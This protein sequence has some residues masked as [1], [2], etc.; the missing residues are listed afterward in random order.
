MSYTPCDHHIQAEKLSRLERGWDSYGASP[1]SPKALEE[2]MNALSQLVLV[3]TVNGGVTLAL[4]MDRWEF[5]LEFGPEGW[6]GFGIFQDAPD[7]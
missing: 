4:R 7:Q 1:I 3:P 6:Y 5:E 2:A